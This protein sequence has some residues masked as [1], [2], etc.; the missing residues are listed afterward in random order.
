[1]IPSRD[2]NLWE[3]TAAVAAPHA[4]SLDVDSKADV[5]VVGAGYLGLSAA[6]HLAEAGVG[7][8]SSSMPTVPAGA[9]RAATAAK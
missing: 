5:L 9:P 7:G 4:P 8:S 3:E 1:V 2:T 6:L